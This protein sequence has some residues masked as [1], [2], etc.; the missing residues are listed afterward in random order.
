[1]RKVKTAGF[2]TRLLCVH[3]LT[4][5]LPLPFETSLIPVAQDTITQDA[6][7]PREGKIRGRQEKS[8]PGSGCASAKDKEAV[9]I[10]CF[11]NMVGFWVVSRVISLFQDLSKLI[12]SPRTARAV[13]CSQ[14]AASVKNPNAVSRASPRH[15][16]ENDAPSNCSDAASSP[17][18]S[19][20]AA[21]RSHSI[22][23]RSHDGGDIN[24]PGVLPSHSADALHDQSE[25]G[26]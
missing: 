13:S 21:G 2:P 26:S 12:M 23:A 3:D 9:V 11:S 10:T 22:R 5:H 4:S 18:Q 20:L 24:T 17:S 7:K 25:L 8:L 14:I 15:V 19:C 1:M 16:T 6:R